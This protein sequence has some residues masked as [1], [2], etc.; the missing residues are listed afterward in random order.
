[1]LLKE[2]METRDKRLGKYSAITLGIILATALVLVQPTMRTSYAQVADLGAPAFEDCSYYGEDQPDDPLGMNTVRVNSIAKTIIVEKE[3][4]RCDTVQ[5][6][7]PLII[8]VTSI[9]EI[10]ENMTSKTIISKQA[11]VITCAKLDVRSIEETTFTTTSTFTETENSWSTVTTTITSTSTTTV[12]AGDGSVSGCDV[13]VPETD[14]VPVSNCW[15]QEIDHPQEVNTV[16]KGNTVK[17]IVAQKEIF[18]CIFDEKNMSPC[19]EYCGRG[20]F[21]T[22][23]KKVEQYIIEEI[24]EDLRLAPSD[25]VVKQNV[26]SLRC[27]TLITEAFVESCQFTDVPVQEFVPEE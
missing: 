20:Y 17:T 22:D 16:N 7:I 13:Y 3:V 27:W 1:L 12:P 4:F 26:E 19:W 15:E 10:L 2:E 23:D 5:G 11:H 8:D 14:F 9:A 24:W 18:V 21:D 25:T 6:D